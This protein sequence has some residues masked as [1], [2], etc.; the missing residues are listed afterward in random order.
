MYDIN[1]KSKLAFIQNSSPK[2]YITSFL[3]VSLNLVYEYP[4]NL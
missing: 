4:A 3:K 1:F 2:F